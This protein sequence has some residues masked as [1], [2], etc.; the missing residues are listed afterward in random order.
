M[1]WLQT[2]HLLCIHDL[3]LALV[4]FT[5]CK[6]RLQTGNFSLASKCSK[7]PDV[8]CAVNEFFTTWVSSTSGVED[9]SHYRSLWWNA[10]VI[11]ILPIEDFSNPKLD[12]ESAD[13][14]I[15]FRFE[16]HWQLKLKATKKL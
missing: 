4:I 13:C 9:S 1:E 10:L 12:I 11:K 15:C 7:S 14:L 6:R 2:L 8:T 16:Y 5:Y 3:A